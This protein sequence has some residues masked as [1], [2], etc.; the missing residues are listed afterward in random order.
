LSGF[1]PINALLGN[2]LFCVQTDQI[3]VTDHANYQDLVASDESGGENLRSRATIEGAPA[4][5]QIAIT[6]SQIAHPSE[7]VAAKGTMGVP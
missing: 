2:W 6:G 5:H 1:L 4:K 7:E 3:P